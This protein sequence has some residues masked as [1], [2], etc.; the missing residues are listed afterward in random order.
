[1]EIEEGEG[2][3]ERGSR[4]QDKGLGDKELSIRGK[5]QRLRKT[6]LFPM[7]IN[8]SSRPWMHKSLLVKKWS[9]EIKDDVG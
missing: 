5:D 9:R 2:E 4:S 6:G 3:H 1:M 8:F 7:V